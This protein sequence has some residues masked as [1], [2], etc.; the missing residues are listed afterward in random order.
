MHHSLMFG[1]VCGLHS[2]LPFGLILILSSSARSDEVVS[3]RG[4]NANTDGT[5]VEVIA[6]FGIETAVPDA[7]SPGT[8]VIV[9]DAAGISFARIVLPTFLSL[10][11]HAVVCVCL[12][13]HL[14]RITLWV[15]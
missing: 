13:E 6:C 8:S 12:E 7:D 9:M 15:P 14:L 1:T 10:L 2:A 3:P 4:A 5:S 11:D